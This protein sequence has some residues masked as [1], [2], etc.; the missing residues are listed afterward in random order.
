MRWLKRLFW[1]VFFVWIVIAF[2]PKSNLFYLAE[3]YLKEQKIIFN[4]EELSDYLGMFDIK[5]SEIFY[6]GLHVGNIEKISFIP[7]IFYNSI[8]LK[9]ANFTDSMK[10][11]VPKNI[12]SLHVRHT[13]FYPIMIF[14]RA[15]GNFGEIK[16]DINLY[17]KSVKLVLSPTPSF[18][19]NYPAI[20]SQLKK[21]EDKYI[22]ETT[23]K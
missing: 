5:N 20:A 21:Q 22:Y 3:N 17:K 9:N 14:I 12:S 23:F 13:L 6:D 7:A 4:N 15:E 10:Q 16:G 1:V 8:A 2:L 18:A 19:K 11:F